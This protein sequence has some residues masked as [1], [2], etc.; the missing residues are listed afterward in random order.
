[1]TRRRAPGEGALYYDAARDRWVGQAEG[2]LN[3]AT[4]TRRRLK[5]SGTT[6]TEAA[7]RLAARIAE[8]EATGARAITVGEV[9]EV[10]LERG[11]SK[12]MS[13]S[14]LKMVSSLVRGHL[15]PVFAAVRADALRVEE[16]EGFL[17]AKAKTLAKSTLVKLRS[18]LAQA[19]DFGIR[20]RSVSWNPARAAEIPA[21]A[22]DRR[23]GRALTAPEA[24]RL[25]RVAE[26]H[27][28]GAFV[29]A[30]LT[31]GLRPGE[32]TALTWEAIDFQAKSV[33]VFRSM[34][35]AE[36][37]AAFKAPKTG[38]TR[39]LAMPAI[40]TESLK[41]HRKAQ[42]TERVLMG[43]RW[44]ADWEAL[45]FVTSNGTPIDPS[46]LRRLVAGLA[47]EAGLKDGLAPYDLRHTATSLLSAAG[48]SA[49]RLADLLGHR[50]T[51]MVHRHYRHP[52]TA[53]VTTAA[54]YDWTA[55][56]V[57]S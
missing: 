9:L 24:R 12:R 41:R 42:A 26:G 39:T 57:G 16:V 13:P 33:T 3:P 8:V 47:E 31:L 27:R 56:G 46:N 35:W 48:Q 2:G 32:A 36:G 20:R 21:A 5:V 52:V 4:G 10:W 1:M 14:T 6:K 50:D 53:A 43:D 11:A 55:A 54:E 37:T 34:T 45:V 40:A 25:L 23:V 17:D 51:R 18:Y 38:R 44:P 19:F 7:R 30:A 29:T 28:M 15:L 22:R 49:E